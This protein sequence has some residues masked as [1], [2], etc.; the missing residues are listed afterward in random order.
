MIKIHTLYNSYKFEEADTVIP[1]KCDD[2]K[3][4]NV[5]KEKDMVQLRIKYWRAKAY[6]K[7]GDYKSG[8]EFAEKYIKELDERFD[9]LRS[10]FQ[11]AEIKEEMLLTV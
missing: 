1:T 9:P 5:D 4:D 7:M 10:H 6:Y 8:L 2:L 11:D 3:G